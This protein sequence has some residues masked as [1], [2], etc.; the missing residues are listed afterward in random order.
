MSGH[1]C[2]S[3]DVWSGRIGDQL[4]LLSLQT[5]AYVT[6]NATATAIWSALASGRTEIMVAGQLAESFGISIAD[7]EST[8]LK[9]CA[10]CR[11]VACSSMR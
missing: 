10:T 9:S 5:G 4:V 1:W 3:H 6:L 7:A 11:A 8:W 2:P